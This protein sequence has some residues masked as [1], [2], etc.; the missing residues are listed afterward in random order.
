MNIIPHQRLYRTLNLDSLSSNESLCYD[1]ILQWYNHECDMG[2][3]RGDSVE[4][5]KLCPTH[6]TQDK[7]QGN[8][9]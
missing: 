1:D 2:S 8:F 3:V 4:G 7:C 9:H 6:Q 5:A